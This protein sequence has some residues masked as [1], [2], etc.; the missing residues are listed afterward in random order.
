MGFRSI[1]FLLNP[2]A[3]VR[4]HA[5]RNDDYVGTRYL[6]EYC[7]L[8]LL[9]AAHVENGVILWDREVSKIQRRLAD[10][11]GLAKNPF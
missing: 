4:V 8:K 1:D 10:R 5:A 9:G 7:V 2:V 6:V 3:V 11:P